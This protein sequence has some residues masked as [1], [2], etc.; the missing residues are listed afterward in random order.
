MRIEVE[1]FKILYRLNYSGIYKVEY[2]YNVII[3]LEMHF[4]RLFSSIAS[5]K[6]CFLVRKMRLPFFSCQSLLLSTTVLM[7]SKD[8]GH[9]LMLWSIGSN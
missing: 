3:V 2:Q 4:N 1:I 7:M 8:S 5:F 9:E 6:V